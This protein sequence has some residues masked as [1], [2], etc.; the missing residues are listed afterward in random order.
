MT[1]KDTLAEAEFLESE[2]EGKVTR[3]CGP[4]DDDN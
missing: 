1:G 2:K 4:S 3:G